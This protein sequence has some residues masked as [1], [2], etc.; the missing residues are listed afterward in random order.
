MLSCSRRELP[1][2][3]KGQRL[4]LGPWDT[5]HTLS[6]SGSPSGREELDKGWEY[7][8]GGSF[9]AYQLMGFL[10]LHPSASSPQEGELQ[11]LDS[12]L[13][14]TLLEYLGKQLSSLGL[15]ALALVRFPELAT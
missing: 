12:R 14:I 3:T 2:P 8:A 1:D 4:D 6:Q 13:R 10:R 11:C 7:L 5:S 15:P 9:R